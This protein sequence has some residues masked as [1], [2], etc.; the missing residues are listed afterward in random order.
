MQHEDITTVPVVH[1]PTST[2]QTSDVKEQPVAPQKV[3]SVVAPPA[4]TGNKTPTTTTTSPSTAVRRVMVTKTV[5]TPQGEWISNDEYV[6]LDS[7]G[8]EVAAPPQS[9]SPPRS[10]TT[11][12]NM[13]G[14]R[15]SQR[16]DENAKK[17]KT[18]EKPNN[19]EKAEKKPDTKK[20]NET[21][22]KTLAAWFKK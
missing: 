20:T 2:V 17:P 1:S 6:W 4:T 22:Q 19:K 8:N 11:V 3:S 16:D 12:S 9:Q 14:K 13:F 21:Q 10:L 5:L 7:E 15:E 18:V